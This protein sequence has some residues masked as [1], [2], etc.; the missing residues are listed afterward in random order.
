[1]STLKVDTLKNGSS[2]SIDFPQNLKIGGNGVMQ[3]YTSSATEP[4]SPAAGDYWWDSSNEELYRYVNGEFKKLTVKAPGVFGDRGFAIGAASPTNVIQYWSMTS[5]G[6]AADFGDLNFNTQS[7]PACSDGT[8]TY[9]LDYVNVNIDYF[10]SATL[11]NATDFGDQRFGNT[12]EGAMESDGTIAVQMHGKSNNAVTAN[13]DKFTVG[14]AGVTAVAFG[15]TSTVSD[16]ILCASYANTERMVTVGGCTSNY[17]AN[18]NT[19]EYITF[20]TESNATD[21]GDLLVARYSLAGA[22]TGEGNIGLSAGGYASTASSQIDRRDVT[23]TANATAHGTLTVSSYYLGGCANGTKAHFFG[24]YN[25]NRIDETN[26][27]STGNATD[28]GDLLSAT[29]YIQGTSGSA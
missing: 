11:G 16:R 4:S 29:Y 12:K 13:I 22:G 8:Y 15:G 14:T 1:M 23:T 9:A 26:L 27:A 5:S 18:Y 24:G 19:C 3:G 7:A 6:N 28:F 10:A 25:T 21:S 20:A 2:G 17:G